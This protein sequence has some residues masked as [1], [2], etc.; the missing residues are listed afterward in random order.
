MSTT[1]GSTLSLRRTPS[2]FP[3]SPTICLAFLG[4]TVSLPSMELGPSTRSPSDMPIEKRRRSLLHLGNTSL[5]GCPSVWPT[6]RPHTLDSSPRLYGINHPRKSFVTWMTLLSTLRMPG[7]TCV[8]CPRSWQ[9]SMLPV[10][11]FPLGRPSCSEIISNTSDTK[12]VPGGSASLQTTRPSSGA[13]R[14]QTP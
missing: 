3:K 11:R 13:G 1:R 5:S 9:L 12:L 7:A 2:P 4:A 6:S 14:F 8:Y 10:S